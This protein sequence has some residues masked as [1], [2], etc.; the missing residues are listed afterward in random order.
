MSEP[1]LIAA[2]KASN[3]A[4]VVAL[5]D[6]GCD[7]HERG[8][9]DWPALNFAAGK[10]QGEIVR[11]LIER[12]ADVW[13]TG[14]DGRTPYEI[15]VAAS[16]MDVAKLL[17]AREEE[18]GGDV[19]RISSRAWEARPYC[20]GYHL[21]ELRAYPGWPESELSDDTV[22]FLH[23]DYSVTR[24]FWTGED[25]LFAGDA[26]EWREFCTQVLDFRVPSELD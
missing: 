22:V 2:I 12:G 9:Q 24:S 5:L 20:K 23:A 21:R 8:E 25:L 13:M 19:A 11:C 6:A 10:G 14:A 15:A 26:A 17:K 16:H 7:V 18:L 4:Q 3:P 1:A